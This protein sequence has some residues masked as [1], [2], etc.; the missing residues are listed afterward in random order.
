MKKASRLLAVLFISGL[1]L[2]ACGDDDTE[3][4][5]ETD[6]DT[7]ELENETSDPVETKT[8]WISI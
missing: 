2:A 6:G 5:E 7:E 3:P 1:L 4:V 8:K